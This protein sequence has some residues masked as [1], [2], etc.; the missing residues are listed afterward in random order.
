MKRYM[1][2]IKSDDRFNAS[3]VKWTY[4]LVENRF[5]KNA[6]IQDEIEGYKTL[7]EPYLVHADGNGNNK[8][9]KKIIMYFVICVS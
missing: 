6:Y 1:R 4:F 5:N 8:T 7:G 9:E 3:S 2:V